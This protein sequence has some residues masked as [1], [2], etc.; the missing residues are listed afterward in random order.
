MCREVIS[1]LS[2]FF[3]QKALL[4]SRRRYLR[5]SR[6]VAAAAWIDRVMEASYDEDLS[7]NKFLQVLRQDYASIFDQAVLQ[8]W[9]VCV[10]RAGS[11]A[12]S[13]LVENDFLGHILVPGDK[14]LSGAQFRTLSGKNVKVCNRVLTVDYDIAKP[15]CAHLLFEEIFYT[16][17]SSKYSL[18]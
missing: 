15:C 18:W 2:F 17:D 8:G 12:K 1:I 3:G 9:I 5:R 13:A 7:E 4:L 11:F 14:S 10:P 6:P 16:D